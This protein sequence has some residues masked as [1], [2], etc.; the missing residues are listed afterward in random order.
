MAAEGGNMADPSSQLV[1]RWGQL[2]KGTS[3]AAK[4]ALASSACWLKR[5][6]WL[7]EEAVSSSCFYIFNY[8]NLL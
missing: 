6:L 1:L 4:E 7:A 2:P 5:F 3:A 8:P